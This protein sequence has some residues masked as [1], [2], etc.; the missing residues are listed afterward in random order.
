MRK[1]LSLLPALLL[2]ACVDTPPTTPQVAEVKQAELGLTGA[3]AP[4]FPQEWWKAF[5]DPQIDRLAALTIANNPTLAGAL[6]RMRAAQAELAVN[7]AQDLP[8]VTLDGSEQRTLF[9]DRY[10]IPPPYGGS[11]RWFG[12]LT[13]NLNWNLDFWGKQAALIA[14]ARGNA[15]AAALDAQAARLALSGAIAQAYVNLLLDY[16]NGD[17]A[18]ATVAEREGILRISQGRFGAGLENGSAVEQAK[19]L[20]SIAKADQ[21][22][23]AAARE[24]D[25]HAIAALTGQGAAAYTT[26]TRP[27]PN[28]D[29]AL[30]LPDRLPADLLA[31]RPDILAAKARVEAAVQGREA[32]HADFYPDINLA[33]LAGFQA[34]GLSNLLSANAFTMGIGPA[35]HLPIFDAGQLKAQYARSTADLDLAVADYNGA[36]LNAI[37]QTADAMTQVR[38][39]AVQRARQQEAVTSAQRAFEIAQERYRSGLATQLPMLTAEATLLQARSSF[40]GVAALGA[41]QRITL[42]LTV[43]GGFEPAH[44][45]KIAKQDTSHD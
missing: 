1:L 6:A 13:A 38:S 9:S 40:A 21:E 15:D 30:P 44:D 43:G 7:Q 11:Y 18:D 17:I 39:L 5:N 36:V 45:T 19:S 34:I 10:I 35:I 14:Q 23:Y 20:L 2:T 32:A 31:R 28:L 25:I 42:L 4:H 22:R 27:R 37:K 12:S 16:Q 26:I 29:V 24:M 8:Q 3:E 33:A 41:Q